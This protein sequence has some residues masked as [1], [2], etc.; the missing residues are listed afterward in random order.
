MGFATYLAMTR[1]IGR[2]REVGLRIAGAIRSSDVVA[3]LD[4][5]RIIAVLPRASL[6]DAWRIADNVCHA[7]E[8]CHPL[9]PE[10]PLLTVSVGVCRIP[11]LCK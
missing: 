1:Q 6:H 7:I 2:L 8:H 5:D 4:D 11:E 3:R 10:L 9:S